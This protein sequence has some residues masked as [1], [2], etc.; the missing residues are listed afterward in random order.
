MNEGDSTVFQE[1][2]TRLQVDMD[3]MKAGMSQA[4]GL[5]EELAENSKHQTAEMAK[6]FI[7][8]ELAVEALKKAFEFLKEAT[9][10]LVKEQ[11][12]AIDH[13]AKLSDQTGITTEHL[14]GLSVAAEENGLSLDTLTSSIQRMERGL[15]DAVDKG[16]G[17]AQDGLD[18]LGLSAQALI[19]LKPDEAFAR[20]AEA[21]Q[22]VG[23][24]SE[25]TRIAVDLL[26]RSGIELVG[27][28]AKGK[29]GL[30]EA[31][32]KAEK[33]GL[34]IS[35]VDARQV[36]AA[37]IAMG[38]IKL[39]I[40]GAARVLTVQLAPYLQVASN[41]IV[42][43]AND[44]TTFRDNMAGA[45]DDIGK[46]LGTMGDII[47]GIYLAWKGLEDGV[48]S[49][50][51]VFWSIVDDFAQG[52]LEIGL[53]L[54]NFLH[55]VGSVGELIRQS[56]IS[57]FEY[58]GDAVGDF[59]KA[60]VQKFGDLVL[61]LGA[62]MVQLG[63]KGSAAVIEAGNAI[64][65]S[66]DGLAGSNA[67]A[68]KATKDAWSNALDEVKLSAKHLL[69]SAEEIQSNNKLIEGALDAAIE[70]QSKAHDELMDVWN[71][72]WPSSGIEASFNHMIELA[73]HANAAVQAEIDERAKKNKALN[74]QQVADAATDLNQYAT[75]LNALRVKENQDYLERQKKAKEEF[76]TLK[77]NQAQR[78]AIMEEIKRQ[79]EAKLADIKNTS[80]ED[81]DAA[82]ARQA[83]F[84]NS[85]NQQKAQFA[86][87]ILANLS[88]LME[89]HNKRLFEVGKIAALG[90]AIIDTAA[91]I[92]RQFADLPIYA[93]IPAAAAVAVAG[94]VQIAKIAS[95]SFQGGGSVGSVGI[96]GSG[97]GAA[98]PSGAAGGATGTKPGVTGQ[99]AQLQTANIIIQSGIND[100]N[101]VRDLAERLKQLVAD[102]GNIGTI[103]VSQ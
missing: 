55:L 43:M 85:T 78:D 96:S 50:G 73:K 71:Q 87:D 37:N 52:F 3:G 15:Q 51:V 29:A 61:D 100:Q 42:D 32:E 89:T 57:A 36:E 41:W 6:G 101:A 97:A 93:A 10:D 39:A 83:A 16:T 9:I 1:L 45:V 13:L 88:T 53:T 33:F 40:E 27:I 35:R 63:V 30:E 22:G 77:L 58:A 75:H 20:V 48:A 2:V 62:G 99:G 84:E 65:N 23:S 31:Q 14:A 72:P 98:P 5:L 44:A 92:V 7:V 86:A 76:E 11:L 103:T 38:D 18:K 34:A 8:A 74:D 46:A 26:G 12:V 25:R 28:L 67:A 56:F 95:T 4:N 102:G 24:Q 21:L 54:G 64:R 47:H 81:Q 59:V 94:G 17:P 19:D 80:I 91:G 79:H 68:A 82:T 70:R 90:K 60:A 66:V 69:P 49:L